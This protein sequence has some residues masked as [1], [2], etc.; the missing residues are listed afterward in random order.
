VPD[1]KPC[2]YLQASN[3]YH[4]KNFVSDFTDKDFEITGL[5]IKKDK[6]EKELAATKVS[7]REREREREQDLLDGWNGNYHRDFTFGNFRNG[8]KKEE[9]ES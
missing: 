3:I 7:N 9:K 2:D 1:Y 8:F 5:E 6:L 4:V